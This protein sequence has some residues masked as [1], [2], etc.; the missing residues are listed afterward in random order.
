M[1]D[2]PKFGLLPSL[3]R[4][5]KAS[6]AALPAESFCERVISAGGHVLTKK[7]LRMDQFRTEKVAILRIN[8]DFLAS[9]RLHYPGMSGYC[10]EQENATTPVDVDLTTA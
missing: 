3:A 5:S 1:E 7:N 4:A 6:L 8:R 9:M 10:D 2:D